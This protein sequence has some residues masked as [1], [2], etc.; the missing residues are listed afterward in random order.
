MNQQVALSKKIQA[1]FKE[2]ESLLGAE[3]TIQAVRMAL[4]REALRYDALGNHTRESKC[5][6]AA[7]VLK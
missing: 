3:A 1:L 5:A 4:E 6:A 7:E 2:Y